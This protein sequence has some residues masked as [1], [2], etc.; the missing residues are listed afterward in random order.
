MGRE[1]QRKSGG[2][3]APLPAADLLY[4]G[5]TGGDELC[6]IVPG[7]NIGDLEIDSSRGCRSCDI[8]LVPIPADFGAVPR[9]YHARCMPQA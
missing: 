7:F 6:G 5:S 8:L 4:A 3:G 9:K 2:P 1:N